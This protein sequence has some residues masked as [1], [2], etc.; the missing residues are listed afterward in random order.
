MGEYASQLKLLDKAAA[1]LIEKLSKDANLLLLTNA[2]KKSITLAT[3]VS[4]RLHAV[5]LYY[6][7]LEFSWELM[8]QTMLALLQSGG[9]VWAAKEMF[10][11]KYPED[12]IF[13]KVFYADAKD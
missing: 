1:L 10:G 5:V 12:G 8:P 7:W 2:S 13:W 3:S 9:V 6:R 4:L 11:K